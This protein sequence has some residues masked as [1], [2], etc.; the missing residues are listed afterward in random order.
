M[1]VE[2][3]KYYT[4]QTCGKTGTNEERI[5]DCEQAHAHLDENETI[6]SE[7]GKG[8]TYPGTL[9]IAMSDGAIGVY[10]LVQTVK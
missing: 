4:C 2:T 10:A 1:K 3:K 9:R 5:R 6:I 8:K 7:Y